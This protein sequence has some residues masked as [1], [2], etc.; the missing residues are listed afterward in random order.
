MNI[1]TIKGIDAEKWIEFKALAAR[2]NVPLGVL[3]GIMINEYAKYS[4]DT[5]SKI[6]EGRK[7][8]SDR[9]AEALAESTKKIRKE[10]GFRI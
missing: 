5:W 1:K 9:D 4:E 2:K 3:F 8:I 10:R 6:L 7:L